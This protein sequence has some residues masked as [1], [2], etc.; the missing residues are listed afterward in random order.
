[1][2]VLVIS[3]GAWYQR[4]CFG[5]DVVRPLCRVYIYVSARVVVVDIVHVEKDRVSVTMRGG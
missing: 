5:I 4:A 2:C 3:V 1:M